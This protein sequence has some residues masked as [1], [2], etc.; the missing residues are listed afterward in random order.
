MSEYT[1][2]VDDQGWTISS[3]DH[4]LSDEE[5]EKFMSGFGR[6][7]LRTDPDATPYQKWLEFTDREGHAH[8]IA[9]VRIRER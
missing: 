2:L 8:F 5:I 4:V 9:S 1:V 6:C 3:F 7:D